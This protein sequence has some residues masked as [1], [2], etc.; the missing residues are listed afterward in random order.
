M[1]QKETKTGY[2]RLPRARAAVAGRRSRIRCG[3]LRVRARRFLVVGLPVRAAVDAAAPD[4]AGADW[5][6]RGRRRD[7][8]SSEAVR[9]AEPCREPHRHSPWTPGWFRGRHTAPFHA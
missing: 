1:R 8:N 5:L 3:T 6:C 4:V 2:V 9:C 7:R